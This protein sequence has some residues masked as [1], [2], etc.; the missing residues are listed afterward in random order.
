MC[1]SSKKLKL[2]SG[3]ICLIAAVFALDTISFGHSLVDYSQTK[4]LEIDL[5]ECIALDQR[6][7]RRESRRSGRHFAQLPAQSRCVD[8]LSQSIALPK[9]TE[10]GQL[11][12]FG[13]FLRI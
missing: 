12:G 6:H 2:L 1:R 7:R 10:R 3:L 5:E 13:G 4:V 11:N 8:L 9:V